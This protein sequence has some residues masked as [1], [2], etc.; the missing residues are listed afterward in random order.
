VGM[1]PVALVRAAS[2]ELKVAKVQVSRQYQQAVFTGG[3]LSYAEKLVKNPATADNYLL[4]NLPIDCPADFS[5]LIC[6]W[7]DIPSRQG[8]M[9]SILVKAI[10]TKPQEATKVYQRL[11]KKIQSIYQ[12]QGNLNPVNLENLALTMNHQ[13]LVSVSK[14]KSSNQKGWKRLLQSWQDIL[15]QLS[16]KFLLNFPIKSSR[17]KFQRLKATITADT[18]YIKFDDTL[19]MV[20]SANPKQQKQLNSY[21]EKEYQAGNLVYGM[22]IS[23]RALMT[24]LVMKSKQR[25]IAFVDGADGGYAL[26]AKALK[27]RL[28]EIS[29]QCLNC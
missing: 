3:G 19:R 28:K 27:S 4:P 7:R 21:L 11:L 10:A 9:L 6:P 17:A 12:A 5:G 20:I 15:V 14:V 13:D 29:Q 24:C 18:D 8:I 25:H 22:H 1:V 2:H 26:A 23:D 16:R